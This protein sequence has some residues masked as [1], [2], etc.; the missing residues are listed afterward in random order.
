M[1]MINDAKII[2]EMLQAFDEIQMPR[3]PYALDQLVV[4]TKHTKEQ[5]YAQCVLELSIAYDNLRTAGA[6]A[7]IKEINISKREKKIAE[8]KLDPA[9]AMDDI[10]IEELELKCERVELEQLNRA[11]LGATR[12]FEY[13]FNK[14]KTYPKK[15]TREELNAASPEEYRMQ[16]LTQANQDLAAM[17][18][19]SQ[20][21]QEGL[22]QIGMAPYP[23]Q[24]DIAR[25]VE[26]RYLET[27]PDAAEEVEKRYLETGQ[28]KVLVVVPTEEKAVNGLPCLEGLSIPSGVQVKYLNVHGRKVDDAYNYA[29]QEALQ[30]KA[31]YV[32]TVEDDTF[33]EPGAFIKLMELI[34]Q[35]P[36]AAVGAWYPKREE[37]KEGVHIII[38]PD[39]K[40]KHLPSDGNVHSVYTIA[41][42]CTL[43][44]IEMFMKIPYPWFKT[45]ENLSQDSF[46]SQLAREAGYELFVDTS[47]KCKHVDRVTGKIYE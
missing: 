46:F 16:L 39:G 33:P 25:D 4:E 41:M 15:F 2:D 20:G 47:I 13:L 9:A 29:V 3:T 10:R 35:H 37:T 42:G 44:P 18:R 30:D 8:M 14:W 11:R 40:R 31:D 12:E 45:T 23:T 6:K 1:H 5:Q 22:R 43:Y 28:C 36:N 38:G 26:K 17:G 27:A 32:L 19:I 34:R 21:N 7:E 24:L